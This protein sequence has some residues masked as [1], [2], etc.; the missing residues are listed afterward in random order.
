MAL[1]QAAMAFAVAMIIFSTI[2]TG[3]VELALR[4]LSMREKCLR[5]A[6]DR[7]FD[8]VVWP[9]LEGENA[10][11]GK[12]NEDVKKNFMAGLLDNPARTNSAMVSMVTKDKR[13]SVLTPLAF[14]QRLGRTDIGRAILEAGEEQLKL[15]VNDFVRTFD[16]FSSAAAEVYRRNAQ[17]SAMLAGIVVAFAANVDAGRLIITLIENPEL[18]QSLVENVDTAIEDSTKAVK[19]LAEAEKIL[20][21]GVEPNA[22]EMQL[23]KEA[24]EKARAS[25]GQLNKL[26][27][28]N[29]PIGSDHFP[30]CQWFEKTPGTCPKDESTSYIRWLFMTILSG[31]LIGLGGP[32]WYRVFTSLSHLFQLVRAL[33]LGKQSP[34]AEPEQLTASST[35][36]ES[37]KPKDIVDAF[38]TAARVQNPDIVPPAAPSESAVA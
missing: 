32:F 23:I 6:V 28:L 8:D 20:D 19:Q 27:N 1:L 30:Y 11:R 17:V 33:G 22:E 37:A 26:E 10:I 3:L 24:V 38:K 5:R 2:A 15:L 13:V 18:R 36:E 29:M 21:T 31:I 25:A 34:E 14:A 4:M 9:R 16:R 35:A 12:S 7:L